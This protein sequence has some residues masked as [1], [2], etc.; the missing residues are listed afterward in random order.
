M[1]F[2]NNLFLRKLLA[3]GIN[4]VNGLCFGAFGGLLAP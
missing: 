2:R 3:W 1:R 4:L